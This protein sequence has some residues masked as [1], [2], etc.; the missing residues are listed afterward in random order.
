VSKEERVE[1][2]EHKKEEKEIVHHVTWNLVERGDRDSIIDCVR[3][4]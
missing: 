1:V 2:F 3:E 4:L